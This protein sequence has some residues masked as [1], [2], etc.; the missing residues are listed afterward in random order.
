M[1]SECRLVVH[2][3]VPQCVFL[4]GQL[5]RDEQYLR[6]LLTDELCLALG[7]DVD[8][9]GNPIGKVSAQSERRGESTVLLEIGARALLC[10]FKLRLALHGSRVNARNSDENYA[11]EVLRPLRNGLKLASSAIRFHLNSKRTTPVPA[12]VVATIHDSVG[13]NARE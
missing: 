1:D 10:G 13:T 4:E 12:P 11:L 6:I 7:L 3:A 2:Q 8:F 5:A 9:G